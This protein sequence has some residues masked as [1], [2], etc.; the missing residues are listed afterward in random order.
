VTI[1]IEKEAAPSGAVLLR[2]RCGHEK[3]IENSK[4]VRGVP[5]QCRACHNVAIARYNRS[6]KGRAKFARRDWRARG[7]LD[8]TWERFQATVKKQRGRCAICQKLPR[9]GRRLDADHCHA[10]GRFRAALCRSCNRDVAR[11][12]AGVRF[13]DRKLN[14][15][16]RAYLERVKEN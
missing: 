10:T 8:I 2:W 9:P 11:F 16:V 3:T 12:E 7:V 13:T 4:F 1:I 6:E 5:K 14:T 15:K